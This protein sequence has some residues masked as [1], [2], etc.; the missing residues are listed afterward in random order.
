M[1][2]IV[3]CSPMHSAKFERGSMPSG[4]ASFW[5]RASTCSQDLRWSAVAVALE[6]SFRPWMACSAV[7]AL[8]CIWSG[9]VAELGV[10]RQGGEGRVRV[11][12]VQHSRARASRGAHD[13]VAE[14][15]HHIP[16]RLDALAERRGVRRVGP[17]A[18]EDGRD[19]A[20]TAMAMLPHL[21]LAPDLHTGSRIHAAQR[22]L[23][24]VDV[25]VELQ[26]RVRLL[27]VSVRPSLPLSRLQYSQLYRHL[28][29]PERFQSD[30]IPLRVPL[31]RRR[32]HNTI[33]GS[34]AI[35]SLTLPK[36]APSCLPPQAAN[37][38]RNATGNAQ[39]QGFICQQSKPRAR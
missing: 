15:L 8:F 31:P 26:H 30:G 3:E 19:R 13:L 4:V 7:E 18:R 24:P 12:E 14:L 37:C 35:H 25:K 6:I 20:V 17:R 28:V 22:D 11:A 29:G 32:P 23:V 33:A 10:N 1:R 16:D 9:A 38:S 5:K 39:L 27:L 2:G 21:L 34:A 36:P